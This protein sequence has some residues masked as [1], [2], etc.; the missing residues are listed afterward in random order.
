MNICFYCR[1]SLS[2]VED[3]F[4]YGLHE[5]CFIKSFS[6]PIATEFQ[7]LL[8]MAS[9]SYA[10]PASAVEASLFA[11]KFRKY[12][13]H[14]NGQQYLLKVQDPKAPEL[15]AVEFLC[16]QLAQ[17][18]G[19]EVPDF[20][21]IRMRGLLTFVSHDF[22]KNDGAIIDLKH[23]THYLPLDGSYTCEVV[24]N[25]ILQETQRLVDG[26]SFVR[27]CLFDALIGNRDRHA[28]NLAFIISSKGKRLAPVYDN[29]SMLGLEEE[30]KFLEAD[31]RADGK[32]A[33]ALT[34]KPAAGD[35][36][37]EFQRLG[38]KDVMEAF[39]HRIPLEDCVHLIQHSFCGPYMKAAMERL[40]RKQYAEIQHALAS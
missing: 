14:L 37:R 27:L 6:L 11:G 3:I 35:Y 31:W 26:E 39:F 29:T 21:L 33:T 19:I 38:K 32:I 17:A 12:L 30:G 22:V 16:N 36:V 9:D 2:A 28:G 34:A 25:I 40:L 1:K 10:P 5:N 7:G 15:P 24:M 4:G 23:L 13:A 18:C 8:R 20:Y